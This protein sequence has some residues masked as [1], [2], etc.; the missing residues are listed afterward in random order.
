M[1]KKQLK[2]CT[3]LLALIFFSSGNIGKGKAHTGIFPFSLME[4]AP[5]ERRTSRRANT[6]TTQLEPVAHH[7][8]HQHD[9]PDMTEL[10]AGDVIAFY[11]PH[12]EARHYLKRGKIQKLPYELFSFGHLAV[13]VEHPASGELK[14]LQVAMKQRCNIDE[15]L[16]YLDGKSWNVYRAPS[17]A[18]DSAR[19]TEFVEHLCHSSH[20]APKYDYTATSGIS[21][22]MIYP[23]TLDEIKSSYTCTTLAVAALH[24]A[25]FSLY[26][27]QRSGFMDVLTPKQV[28]SAWGAPRH[29]ASATLTMAQ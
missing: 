26:P 20:P 14:L 16:S 1:N 19:L 13:V 8:H 10:Q 28:I 24:Y 3:F 15:D 23:N 29:K 21:N 7:N 27:M 6:A 9:A 17:G 18:I 22:G 12:K 2:L 5:S 4:K 11:M 25:G